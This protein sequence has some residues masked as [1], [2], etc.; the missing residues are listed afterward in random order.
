MTNEKAR[1]VLDDVKA[2]LASRAILE[3]EMLAGHTFID[4]C[5]AIKVLEQQ[6]MRD[7][8]EEERK[9]VKDYIESIS[10]PTGF[11][12]YEAQPSEDCIS[13]EAAIKN[14]KWWFDLIELNPDILIDSMITLPSVTPQRPK[15][16]WIDVLDEK[17]AYSETHHFECSICGCG[18]SWISELEK[19]C[20]NCGAEMSGGEE[21]GNSN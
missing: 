21:D 2:Y 20:P 9:S 1:E 4:I 17:T 6:L 15:G 18:S 3:N 8:T 14:I 5:K 7:A 11:N 12:F 16:K 10:K 13:R 19:Y